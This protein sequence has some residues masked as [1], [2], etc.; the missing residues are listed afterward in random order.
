MAPDSP[1]ISGPRVDVNFSVQPGPDGTPWVGI[2]V[3]HG[4]VTFVLVVSIPM[5]N[6][7]AERIPEGLRAAVTKA[8]EADDQQVSKTI[9]TIPANALDELKKRMQP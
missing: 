9:Q 4:L 1:D 7:M 3:T 2:H 8:T 6:T 5:A